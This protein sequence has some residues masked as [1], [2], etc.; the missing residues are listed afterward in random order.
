MT[1]EFET[2]VVGE[3]GELRVGAWAVE[4]D[5]LDGMMASIK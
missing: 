1:D 4:D 2:R 5:E 3:L